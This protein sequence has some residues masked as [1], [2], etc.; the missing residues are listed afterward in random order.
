M[1]YSVC[2][3]PNNVSIILYRIKYHY[4]NRKLYVV[5]ITADSFNKHDRIV[6]EVHED[7]PCQHSRA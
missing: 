5:V 1:L 3:G 2:T 7:P 4:N 6:S